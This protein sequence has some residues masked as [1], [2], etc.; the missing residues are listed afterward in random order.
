MKNIIL[1]IA[2]TISLV[3]C[4]AQQEDSSRG[5]KVEVGEMAP[6][7]DLRLLDGGRV[8]SESLKGKVAVLQF[9]A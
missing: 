5:Y 1:I 2:F 4:T 8:T 7:I 6:Q 9:T 3:S